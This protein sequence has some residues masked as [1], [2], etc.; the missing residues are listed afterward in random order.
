MKQG[1]K[2]LEKNDIPVD[3]T[4]LYTYH[5]IGP[6]STLAVYGKREHTASTLKAIA[7]QGAGFNEQNYLTRTQQRVELASATVETAPVFGTTVI[8][9]ATAPS[10][11]PITLAAADTTS[12]NLPAT[13]PVTQGA[14]PVIEIRPV[15]ANGS[16]QIAQPASRTPTVENT[17]PTT[18][19]Q[20]P[21]DIYR[22]R[23]GHLI[24]VA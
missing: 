5:N 23:N 20:K 16:T 15:Q 14:A 19:G 24:A 10:A 18:K 22:D 12:I 1:T 21:Q 13:A 17:V 3:A 11:T 6:T 8:A 7:N 9:S 4:A 2:F